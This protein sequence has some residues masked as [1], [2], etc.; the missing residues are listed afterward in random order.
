MAAEKNRRLLIERVIHAPREMVWKAWTDPK[1]I[2]K[3]WGPNGFTTTIETME[4]RPG[5]VWT[6]VMHG[7]DGTD[8]AN[9]STFI[10]VVPPER[11][12]FAHGGGSAD[13]PRAQ[14][15]S[16]R[17]FQALGR[18]QTRVSIDMVFPTAADRDRIVQY[19][20]AIE[21]G[22]QTLRRLSELLEP[23]DGRAG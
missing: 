9:K 1:Q 3:W 22:H 14:F 23:P 15:E 10:E 21:G 13:G 2:V 4:V 11:I 5:G 18:D 12:V 6:F 17:T 16:R 7:P 8:Y 19:Y 20:G